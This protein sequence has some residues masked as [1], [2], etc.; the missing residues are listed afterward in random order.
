MLLNTKLNAEHLYFN[1][2]RIR[3]GHIQDELRR[4]TNRPLLNGR[5]ASFVN[6][7]INNSFNIYAKTIS[8]WIYREANGTYNNLI[9]NTDDFGTI[10]LYNDHLLLRWQVNRHGFPTTTQ[11]RA[12]YIP[13]N[14]WVHVAIV[15]PDLGGLITDT[16]IYSSGYADFTNFVQ[17]GT[18]G[19]DTEDRIRYHNITPI[20]NGNWATCKIYDL[21]IWSERWSAEDVRFYHTYKKLPVHRPGNEFLKTNLLKDI[22]MLHYKFEE[23]SGTTVYDSS[24]NGRNGTWNTDKSSNHY[25]NKNVPHSYLNSSGYNLVDGVYIP[26]NESNPIYDVLG[27][28]LEFA[29]LAPVNI[30]T[31]TQTVGNWYEPNTAI[32]F[33]A[34]VESPYLKSLELHN[35]L[36]TVWMPNNPTPTINY[37]EINGKVDRITT[38]STPPINQ[39]LERLKAFLNKHSTP[40]TYEPPVETA[41][42]AKAI[43]DR[44]SISYPDAPIMLTNSMRD[45]NGEIHIKN[46]R[47]NSNDPAIRCIDTSQLS[48]RTKIYIEDCVLKGLGMIIYAYNYRHDFVIRNNIFFGNKHLSAN[49]TS[50]WGFWALR[51]NNPYFLVF[52]NNYIEDCGTVKVEYTTELDT[53]GYNIRYNYI[54]NTWQPNH[55]NQAINIKGITGTSVPNQVI[56]YNEIWGEPGHVWVEDT[57]NIYSMRAPD[58]SPA[59]IRHN[60][61]SGAFKSVTADR[62][63]GGGF[64][65]DGTSAN[66]ES[67]VS[68]NWILEHNIMVGLGNYCLALAMSVNCIIR[69][70]TCIVA[71]KYADGTNYPFWVSGI[72]TNDYSK[73]YIAKGNSVYGNTVGVYKYKDGVGRNDYG[74]YLLDKEPELPTHTTWY[75]NVSLPDP[76]T[77]EMEYQQH[78]VW[79]QKISNAGFMMG[80]IELIP[81]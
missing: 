45:I 17:Q 35:A 52:E 13:A 71:G 29:G 62:Y 24:G 37:R 9:G 53:Q 81:N 28:K 65:I 77:K 10:R 2:R 48:I 26:A 80:P 63:T 18:E 30:P 34:G 7:H 50:D 1:T 3:N 39:N 69:N 40:P 22:L 4:G 15:L 23:G 32:D 76:I 25:L 73:N 14:Q 20:V 66:G 36:P 57:I 54:K 56:E 6:N 47:I 42:R 16:K 19:F 74:Y 64:I 61:C 5:C 11:F 21:Q 46:K 70:N 44:D 38:N 79:Q 43:P 55:L 12:S 41:Y 72:W 49:Y 58:N 59:Y 68:K 8:F 31:T 27:N 51:I 67:D 33:S 60:F 75:D 78:T